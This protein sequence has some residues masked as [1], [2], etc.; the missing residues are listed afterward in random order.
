MGKIFLQINPAKVAFIN[1]LIVVWEGL[2][3]KSKENS[4]KINITPYGENF[5]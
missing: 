4:L 1:I 2:I 3:E 5:C